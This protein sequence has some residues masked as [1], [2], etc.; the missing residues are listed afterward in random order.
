MNFLNAQTREELEMA[1]E[2]NT[3][4]KKATDTLISMSEEEEARIRYE[5][6]KEFLFDQQYSLQEAE[7]KGRAEGRAE[8]IKSVKQE[9]AK[10]LIQ[11]G[12]EE[13]FIQEVTGLDIEEIRAIW[14]N[15]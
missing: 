8:G 11:K 14:K 9:T 2:A 5:L 6:R 15:V 7:R 13:Q 12:M 10:I 1:E 3:T 4:I